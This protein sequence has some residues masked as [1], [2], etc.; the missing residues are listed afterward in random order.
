M[1]EIGT[2]AEIEKFIKDNFN[3][4]GFNEYSYH[5]VQ[6]FIKLYLSQF[7]KFEGKLKFTG[8]KG[9]DITKKCI[10]YF[11][12][13]TKYFTNGGF[14]KLIMK[15]KYIK[16]IFELC[17][18]AYESDLS[19]AKFDT[20]LIFIDKKANQFKFEKFPD[21]NEEEENVRK[22]NKINNKNVDIVY[23]LM[24]PV[25]WELKLKLQ[26]KML[27]KFLKN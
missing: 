25:Q 1:N 24:P 2:N 18:D 5:Q 7:D 9:E 26:K 13:S 11:V 23:L 3:S 8:S 20:P 22:I 4:I 16:D 19:R 14:A 15:K 27:L 12:N 6:T 17:L 21:I 10:D